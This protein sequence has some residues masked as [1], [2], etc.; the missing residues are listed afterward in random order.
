MKTVDNKDDMI[1][2][3]KRETGRLHSPGGL[4]RHCGTFNICKVASV[5]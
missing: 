2:M 3:G 1:K 5:N 4:D